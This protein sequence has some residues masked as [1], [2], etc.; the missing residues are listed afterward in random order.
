M[1]RFYSATGETTPNRLTNW[2]ASI[3]DCCCELN[4][5]GWQGVGFASEEVPPAIAVPVTW[6]LGFVGYLKGRSHYIFSFAFVYAGC[7]QSI[8]PQRLSAGFVPES[9]M[10]SG[11]RRAFYSPGGHLFSLPSLNKL[12]LD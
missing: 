3:M 8:Y 2:F 11:G 6:C 9:R 4:P 5:R 1:P 10:H 7:A 12:S